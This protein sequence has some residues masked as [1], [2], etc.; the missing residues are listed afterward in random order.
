MSLRNVLFFFF[1]YNIEGRG[2]KS[3]LKPCY[4]DGKK[5]RHTNIRC[6]FGAA[7]CE[8]YHLKRWHQ[9]SS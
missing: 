2:K 8:I 3:R 1:S 7:R 4:L 5:C 6:I 9:S